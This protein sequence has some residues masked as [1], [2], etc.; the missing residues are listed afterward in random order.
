MKTARIWYLIYYILVSF[1][2]A[3][4]RFDFLVITISLIIQIIEIES[5]ALAFVLPLR[6]FRY[7][8]MCCIACIHCRSFAQLIV[9]LSKKC[10]FWEL[11]MITR[12]VGV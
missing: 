2:V 6:F 7:L 10:N 1:F 9:T 8:C 3:H 4:F 5:P 12:T 11:F